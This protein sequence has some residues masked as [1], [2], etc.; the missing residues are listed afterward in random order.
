MR[1]PP[2]HKALAAALVLAL[3]LPLAGCSMSF[4]SASAKALA[5][6]DGVE[7][8]HAE[9]ELSLG[10]SA[11]ILGDSA[12]W[13][14]S[15]GISMDTDGSRTS[16]SLSLDGGSGARYIV[17]D[18]GG[19]YDL[20]ISA[21]GGE[22]WLSF[23]GLDAE[24]RADADAA[25]E[26]DLGGLLTLYL[27]AASGF[28]GEIEDTAPTG[29]SCRRYDGFFPGERLAEAF[30]LS[31]S[32]AYAGLPEGTDFPDVPMSVWFY[33]DGGL[34]ARVELDVTEAMGAYFDGVFEGLAGVTLGIER[35][36]MSVALS[37]Y[38]TA[39]PATPPAA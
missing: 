35:L 12:D 21:D 24:E 7:S 15:L 16:G 5:A 26:V 3:A 10:A 28:S 25:P 11:G 37:G 34:P 13:D 8:V 38:N 6:L 33:R 29:E 22:E 9:L 14:V 1:R 36:V 19:E 4:E 17:E 23:T 32:G 31:G 39:V 2:L 30:E 20:Y 18:R 27:E